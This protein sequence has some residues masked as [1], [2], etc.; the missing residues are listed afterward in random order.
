M[1][2]A[3]AAWSPLLIDPSTATCHST[4][5]R[6]AR[7]RND[8]QPLT[9]PVHQPGTGAGAPHLTPV[10]REQPGA[11]PTSLPAL[12]SLRRPAST[13]RTYGRCAVDPAGRSLTPTPQPGAP[14]SRRSAA[15]RKITNKNPELTG[16]A[17]SGMT[18]GFSTTACKPDKS[19]TQSRHSARPPAAPTRPPLDFWLYRRSSG[20]L[21]RYQDIQ[22][23]AT[24]TYVITSANDRSP[25]VYLQ[26]L[27]TST[28][29]GVNRCT[30]R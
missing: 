23:P 24:L 16:P 1:T 7:R 14:K 21:G 5:C 20:F 22:R 3:A 30:H 17:P 26:G 28:S 11:P 27:A 18:Q 25:G 12:N 19:T 2:P 6:P 10:D 29:S 4:P 9:G 15:K 8:R 13:S